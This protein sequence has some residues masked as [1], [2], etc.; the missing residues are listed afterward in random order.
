MLACTQ[1]HQSKKYAIMFYKSSN[2]IGIRRKFEECQ[3]VFSYGGK[4]S[5]W[6][7]VELRKL[8][9]AVLKRL[10]E[11]VSEKDVETWAKRRV[12][13]NDKA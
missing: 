13:E 11:G 1:E 3:Q 6:T 2:A 10:D 12:S 5:G 7:E 8:G 4:R 9:D